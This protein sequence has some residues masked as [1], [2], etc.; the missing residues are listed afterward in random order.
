MARFEQL[1]IVV[2]AVL[3]AGI[4]VQFLALQAEFSSLSQSIQGASSDL[5]KEISSLRDKTSALEQKL[6]A[7]TAQ[8]KEGEPFSYAELY[9]KV[10]DSVVSINIVRGGPFSA[11]GQ[12]SGFVFDESGQV[13][14]NNHVVAGAVRIEVE[15]PDGT[16]TLAELVGSDIYSDIA[17]IKIRTTRTLKPIALG[18]SSQLRVGDPIVSIGNPFGLSGSLT[19]GVI[20]QLGR[21]LEVRTSVGR[22]SIPNVIQIDAAIN[23][24]NSG[25]PLLNRFGQVVGITTAIETQ[26]GTF[27]GVGFAIPVNTIKREISSLITLGKFDHP[28]LGAAGAD[29]TSSIAEAIGARSSKGW[30]VTEVVRNGPADKAGVRGGNRVIAVGG[31]S[32]RIGG[33]IIVAIDGFS[34]R[35]GDELTS[36]LEEK[37]KPGH[38]VKITV[39]RNRETIS[40]DVILGIR[41]PP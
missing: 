3:S 39:E 21:T 24:G 29:M 10:K 34:V 31:T 5:G 33:D 22:Y 41:P 6:N 32:I 40:I 11:G 14:T 12:G 15:F 38:R 20:S 35:N 13:I 18:D 25:G 19:T 2:L 28:W 27:S 36:Y 8:Q 16:I 7:V 17:I 23:P 37:T 30:L 4:L 1:G 26:T 9:D